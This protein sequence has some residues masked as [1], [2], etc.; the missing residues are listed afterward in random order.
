[1]CYLWSFQMAA[2]VIMYIYVYIDIVAWKWRLHITVSQHGHY[3]LIYIHSWSILCVTSLLLYC[4]ERSI[5]CDG[6]SF[7]YG[8]TSL[9]YGG[10]SYIV[11]KHHYIVIELSY[12]VMD[13]PYNVVGLPYIA[14][15]HPYT[16]EHRYSTE[17]GVHGSDRFSYPIRVIDVEAYLAQ[18][19]VTTVKSEDAPVWPRLTN[20]YEM[21]CSN[22][23]CISPIIW[24][25]YIVV[26]YKYWLIN[27]SCNKSV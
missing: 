3:L 5:Y 22:L 14:V 26:L 13:L 24:C 19:A 25:W 8:G 10:T 9:L 6:T 21:K 11:L 2:T 4:G 27:I 18:Q 1:M 16:V 23:S 15:E 12:I 7:C 20:L 17:F